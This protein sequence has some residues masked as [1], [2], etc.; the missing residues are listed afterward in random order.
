M[1]KYKASLHFYI[2]KYQA[3]FSI[4]FKCYIFNIFFLINYID[5]FKFN[6]TKFVTSYFQQMT[7]QNFEN[8][9]HSTLI[10]GEECQL[11]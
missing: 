2:G 5:T 4:L 7:F 1:K 6:E 3:L 11:I 8:N 9:S 10:L